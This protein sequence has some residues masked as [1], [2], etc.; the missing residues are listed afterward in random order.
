M[1]R[2]RS[3][4]VVV[5]GDFNFPNIWDSLSVRGLDAAEF[6]RSILDGFLEQYVNSPTREEV[7]LDLVFGNETIQVVGVSVGD[8]FGNSDHNS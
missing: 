8:Y 5:T 6:V 1:E 3:N 2:C 7:I 4:R